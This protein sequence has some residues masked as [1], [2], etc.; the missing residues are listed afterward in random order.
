VFTESGREKFLSLGCAEVQNSIDLPRVRL[1]FSV[2]IVQYR[3]ILAVWADGD[4][5]RKLF[6]KPNVPESE[7]RQEFGCWKRD[8]SRISVLG[9]GDK[10][11]GVHKFMGYRTRQIHAREDL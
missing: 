9:N 4:R 7:I 2:P 11:T 6:R 3:C 1:S 10:E 5:C 8:K